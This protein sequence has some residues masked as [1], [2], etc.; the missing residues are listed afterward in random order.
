M[1][2]EVPKREVGMREVLVV[3]VWFGRSYK[4]EK[5]VTANSFHFYTYIPFNLC[6]IRTCR[7]TL[8]LLTLLI[9][10]LHIVSPH[11][12]YNLIYT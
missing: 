4:K 8:Y 12:L 11:A 2:D 10:L 5:L 9:P 1:C 7:S 6:L 3:E